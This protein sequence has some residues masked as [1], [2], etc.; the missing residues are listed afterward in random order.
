[1]VKFLKTHFFFRW[2]DFYIGWYY[3]QTKKVLYILPLPMFGFKVFF[4]HPEIVY[5]QMIV[6]QDFFNRQGI[7]G[8]LTYVWKER[9]NENVRV[10]KVYRVEE[11]R[12]WADPYQK[13]V[14]LIIK[15][16]LHG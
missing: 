7:H 1:M 10:G 12:I 16:T 14:T 3:D 8:I 15:C 5:Q 11:T 4:K 9:I 6:T 2:Y 13:K